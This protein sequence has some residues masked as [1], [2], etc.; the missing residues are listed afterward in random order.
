MSQNERFLKRLK[1]DTLLTS[2]VN[3]SV[4]NDTKLKILQCVNCRI[5][6]KIT[7]SQ[8]AEMFNVSIETIKRFEKFESNNL[9]LYINYMNYFK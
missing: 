9:C 2:I 3:E 5:E 4:K 7:Q 1:N 8:V 6:R